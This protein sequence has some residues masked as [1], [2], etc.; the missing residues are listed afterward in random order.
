MPNKKETS[1]KPLKS[2]FTALLIIYCVIFYSL[3]IGYKTF[4]YNPIRSSWLA[5]YGLNL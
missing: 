1:M 5:G 2:L 4:L 3:Y